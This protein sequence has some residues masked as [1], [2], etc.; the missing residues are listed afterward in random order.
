MCKVNFVADDTQEELWQPPYDIDAPLHRFLAHGT[1][2]FRFRY[3]VSSETRTAWFEEA[4]YGIHFSMGGY[5][6][7][8]KNIVSWDSV[9]QEFLISWTELYE[10]FVEG[11]RL[12]KFRL[13][14]SRKEIK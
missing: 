6:F 4:R 9:N 12:T 2:A 5:R 1:A 8:V 3:P 13:A 10:A 14:E 7:D 11:I